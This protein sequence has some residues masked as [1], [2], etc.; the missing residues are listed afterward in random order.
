MSNNLNDNTVLL[1]GTGPMAVAYA[2]VL[3]GLRVEFQVIGRGETSA[4]NFFN[5]TGKKPIIGGL[6]SFLK[7]NDVS[8]FRAAIIAT[9]TEALLSCLKLL[10][11]H[12]IAKIL[13][14]KPAALSIDELNT[15]KEIFMPF[16]SAIY[17]AYNRRFY[18]SVL[19]TERLLELDGGLEAMNFEF[20]EW[21]HKIDP[22][23]KVSSVLNN[24]FFANST[25]VVDLAFFLAG[26]P[27]DWIAYSKK[28]NLE[29]HDKTV[30]SGAGIT[31]KGVLF[32]YLSHWESAG[33]WGIELLTSKNKIYLKPLEG[34]LVQP[35][36]TITPQNHVF[37]DVLD[38]EYKPGLYK[39]V[40][41]FLSGNTSRF[42]TINE[43]LEIGL[44]IYQKM[45][46]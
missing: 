4:Q 12:S 28:G 11:T 27:L 24:W 40:E 29:W 32:S 41:A 18:A 33:R 21:T 39:Q 2:K 42:I 30:F 9:G 34:I 38:H 26:K 5:E 44:Q 8:T 45:L 25:H 13:I 43:Q 15:N 17:V 7:H 23:K 16:A 14:E 10:I 20:T 1:I 36:G 19:E 6:E 31:E 46:L 3:Q 35:K 22:T 37:D